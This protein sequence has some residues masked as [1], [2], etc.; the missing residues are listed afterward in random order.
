MSSFPDPPSGFLSRRTAKSGATYSPSCAAR[1][2]DRTRTPPPT[3]SRE[4]PI[5]YTKT[6]YENKNDLG[7]WVRAHTSWSE[8]SAEEGS[9]V[10]VG[11]FEGGDMKLSA[12]TLGPAVDFPSPSKNDTEKT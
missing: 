1:S 5:Y 2:G 12:G 6:C 11:K 4:R 3:C 8:D 9:E 7:S 10:R